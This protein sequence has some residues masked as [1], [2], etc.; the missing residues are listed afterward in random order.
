MIECKKEINKMKVQR[1]FEEIL[2]EEDNKEKIRKQ[3]EIYL[4]KI[5]EIENSIDPGEQDNDIDNLRK[6]IKE[7]RSQLK[8]SYL[9]EMAADEKSNRIKALQAQVAQV[10]DELRN[11]DSKDVAR[12]QQITNRRFEL[13]KQL[14][15]LKQIEV[16]K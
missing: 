8:E 16:T 12:K 2:D 10:T 4:D 14:N 5:D 11:V 3:I 15:T 13:L 6:K 1:L 7:L 9:S